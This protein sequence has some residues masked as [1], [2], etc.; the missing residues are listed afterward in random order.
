MTFRLLTAAW[1]LAAT[2]AIAKGW[3]HVSKEELDR[4]IANEAMALV[5]CECRSVQI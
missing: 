2:A 5:A 4:V 3:S 1:L